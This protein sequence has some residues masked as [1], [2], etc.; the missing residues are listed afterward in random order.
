MNF[1]DSAKKNLANSIF[2]KCLNL[3][4]YK[5]R[6]KIIFTIITQSIAGFLDAV[7]VVLIGLIGGLLIYQSTPIDKN[8]RIA[9]FLSMFGLEA[10]TRTNQLLVLGVLAVLFLLIKS[11]LSIIIIQKSFLYFFKLS[12][13]LSKQI[14]EKIF[15]LPISRLNNFSL[16]SNNYI[17]ST[18]AYQVSLIL[19]S[20]SNLISDVFLCLILFIGL[21][22]TNLNI[23]VVVVVLFGFTIF[24]MYKIYRDKAFRYG[25]IRAETNIRGSELFYDAI[26]SVRELSVSGRIGNYV[27]SIVSKIQEGAINESRIAFIPFFNKYIL[28]IVLILTI[29]I[30]GIFQFTVSNPAHAITVITIFLAASL[31]IV[32]ALLRIQQNLI[33]IKNTAG[34]ALE[35]I[36]FMNE[37]D[38]VK[39]ESFTD[40][41]FIN[42]RKGF[43]SVV[44]IDDLYFKYPDNSEF[45]LKIPKLII[46]EFETV[47]IVGKSG[48][49]KSTFVDLILGLN[50]PAKG[51]IKI[52]GL[53][54]K[55]AISKFPG[56]ISYVPQDFH[57]INGTIKENI[58]LGLN[59]EDVSDMEIYDVL[60]ASQLIDF[61]NGLPNNLNSWIGDR[62]A[63]L[64]GGQK[65]RMSIARALLTKPNLLILDEA[66]SALDA[67][68]EREFTKFLDS[69]KNKL[70]IIII[71]H[72]LS[73]IKNVP[74][75]LYLEQGEVKGCSDF[76]TLRKTNSNFET[77]T[78]LS[79]LD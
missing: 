57:M 79:L 11:I 56:A 70:T 69:T 6:T 48:S 60:R 55:E 26:Q 22:I 49:G 32:P 78:K 59:S 5:D 41:R 54:P 62:G 2:I 21:A 53:N 7:G 19:S 66:T 46:E 28:E 29:F 18:G 37:L 10:K 3:F 36:N 23:F 16:Q 38:D 74:K 64:S 45:E 52:S 75:I 31:R 13:K 20:Y 50:T 9:I 40:S 17:S 71:A 8:S 39:V 24:T 58:C 15:S 34:V 42:F 61:V 68:T 73:T 76:E 14:I 4:P 51:T 1:K 65:Q 67:E 33:S 35:T 25:K 12:S 77:Q 63:K 47:A 27:Q 72:R 44:K 43:R 30:L